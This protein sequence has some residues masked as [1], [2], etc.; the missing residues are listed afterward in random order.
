MKITAISGLLLVVAAQ[1]VSAE[2]TKEE[3]AERVSY[4]GKK[5]KPPAPTED[6]VELA[7]PTPAA[8]G[9][10]YITVDGQ[11]GQIKIEATKGRPLVRS[12]RI[13]YRNGKHKVVK[14]DRL[15]GRGAST[16]IQIQGQHDITQIVVDTDWKSRGMYTV[17]GARPGDVA[18]R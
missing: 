9:R 8:H 13:D 2:P 16:T 11:Y 17:H 18:T 5:A 12:V 7:T 10:E 14:L 6:W 15:L 3:T 1:V 4:S